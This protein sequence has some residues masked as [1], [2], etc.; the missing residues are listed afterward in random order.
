MGLTSSAFSLCLARWSSPPLAIF[1]LVISSSLGFLPVNMVVLP[2][3]RTGVALT[4]IQLQVL[5]IRLISVPTVWEPSRTSGPTA[6]PLVGSM[7]KPGP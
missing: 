5:E 3:I 6:R 1:K 7:R 2:V 4:T